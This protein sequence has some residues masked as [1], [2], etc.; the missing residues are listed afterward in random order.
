MEWLAP[1]VTAEPRPARVRNERRG[2][3]PVFFSLSYAEMHRDKWWIH[4]PDSI[5]DASLLQAATTLSISVRF[6]LNVYL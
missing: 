2:R 5:A 4:I 3:D 1:L 6:N